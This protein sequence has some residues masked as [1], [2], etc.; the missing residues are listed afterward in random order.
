MNRRNSSGLR[1]NISKHC[2]EIVAR[3]R[4][5]ST[6]SKGDT[7]LADRLFHTQLFVQNWNH[8]D[9][10]MISTSSHTFTR[11]SV[12]TISWTLSMISGEADSIGR[13]EWGTS[14]VDVRPRLNLFTQLYSRKCWCRC[15][16]NLWTLS[17]SALISFGVK[18]FTCRCLITSRNSF[19]SILQK[20]KD[21]MD[22]LIV[23]RNETTRWIPLKIWQ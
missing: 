11:R 8:C 15:A 23:Y 6:V 19:F 5:W 14:H 22:A 17:N 1:W 10:P 9:M 2:F 16:M 12:K 13:P 20:N 7:H 21:S 18:L 4:L 3:S